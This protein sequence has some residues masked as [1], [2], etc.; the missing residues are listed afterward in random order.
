MIKNVY[1]SSCKVPVILVRL[2]WNL[3]FFD[4]FSKCRQTSNFI[5]CCVGAELLHAVGRTDRRTDGQR[6]ERD[7]NNIRFSQFCERPWNIFRR[8]WSLMLAALKGWYVCYFP[9]VVTIWNK[10]QLRQGRCLFCWKVCGMCLPLPLWNETAR[11]GPRRTLYLFNTT[12][13]HFG[14]P[15]VCLRPAVMQKKK[16][17]N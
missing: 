16:K 17:R 13:G 11:I 2:Y 12:N 5:I 1:W 3:N 9:H 7:E 4:R 8:F 14:T 10:S 15:P 6:D